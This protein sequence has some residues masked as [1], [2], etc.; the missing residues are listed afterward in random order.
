MGAFKNATA[1][2]DTGMLALRLG[3]P[4]AIVTTTPKNIEIIR[5]LLADPKVVV[6]RDSTYSNRSNLPESFFSSIVGRYAGTRLS[7]QEIEGQLLLDV[8]GALW[9]ASWIE[10][11][12]V[13]P[14]RKIRMKKVVVA[15]DPAV[16]ASE[17]SCETGLVVAGVGEQDHRLYLMVDASGKYS[18][19][20]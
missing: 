19:D 1:T 10:D 9:Q 6:T 14:A 4:K 12:R 20:G 2:Y 15:L 3:D 13:D 11:H 7:K 17:T 5:R 16:V 18:T 8:P